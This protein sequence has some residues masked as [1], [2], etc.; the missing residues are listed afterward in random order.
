MF[1]APMSKKLD[2]DLA[3]VPTWAEYDS[4]RRPHRPDEFEKTDKL[5]ILVMPGW[6][7]ANV[8]ALEALDGNAWP[9]LKHP[10]PSGATLR[11]HASVFVWLY[12]SDGRRAD[13]EQ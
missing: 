11:N 7:A 6:T 9:S 3:Y 12:G 2:A 1:L 8:G 10:W 5:G 4:A 13:V